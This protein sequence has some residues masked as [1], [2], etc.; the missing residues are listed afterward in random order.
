VSPCLLLLLELLLPHQA[1]NISSRIVDGVP[2]N[3]YLQEKIFCTFV[4]NTWCLGKV[5]NHG[6]R[7]IQMWQLLYSHC[8]N[9]WS[10]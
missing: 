3:K 1:W 6:I 4:Q 8:W 9:M 2:P 7:M 10:M 5:V